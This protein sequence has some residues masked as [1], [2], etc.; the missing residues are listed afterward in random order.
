MP[1]KPD[2]AVWA[3]H[4]SP[5]S[6]EASL[7]RQRRQWSAGPFTE[8]TGVSRVGQIHKPILCRA[9]QAQGVSGTGP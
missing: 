3:D 2:Q 4:H 7:L 6:R 1:K 5:D 9:V 8:A